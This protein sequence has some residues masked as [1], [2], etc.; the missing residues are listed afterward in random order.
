MLRAE[1]LRRE[2]GSVELI[3]ADLKTET[4]ENAKT[5]GKFEKV[6]G[7][8]SFQNF[9]W[10]QM[11]IDRCR[12]VACVCKETG[13]GFGTGFLVRG[14]DLHEPLGEE[15]LLLTNAHVVSNDPQVRGA[16]HPDETFI[17]FEA[18]GLRK[19]LVK[20]LLWT[21]PPHELDASLLRLSKPV[22][23]VIPYPVAPRLPLADGQQ[24]IYIVGHPR[25]G[26]LS[27]SLHDNLLL[28]HQDP[29]IHYRTPTE[30]GSSGSPVFNQQWRL[31]GLH[32]LGDAQMSRL[33]GKPGTYE[34]NEGIWIGAIKEA[35]VS[36]LKK[37]CGY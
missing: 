15:F 33:H 27:F 1:L 17:S 3:A 13:E 6:F 26:K 28:D 36:A 7:K 14:S 29:R 21:S 32:H 8:D 16:L 18:L 12:A 31:V 24:R 22:G 25:G 4:L 5:D 11:G 20:E 2:G 9:E 30:G 34:A 19:I 23:G 10:Y 35:I 37:S